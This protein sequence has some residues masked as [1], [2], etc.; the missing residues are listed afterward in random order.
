[1]WGTTAKGGVYNA[2]AIFKMNS[3]DGA[4]SQEAVAHSFNP[5]NG[6]GYEPYGG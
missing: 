4:W 5:S 6:D 2:G 1:M 3:P